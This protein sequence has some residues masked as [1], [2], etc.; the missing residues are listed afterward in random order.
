MAVRKLSYTLAAVGMIAGTTAQ[1][2]APLDVSVRSSA[3]MGEAEQLGRNHEW[4]PVIVAMLAIL[5]IIV[6]AGDDDP[7]SP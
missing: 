5:S 6:F 1:A 4:I 2:T 7:V 3:A